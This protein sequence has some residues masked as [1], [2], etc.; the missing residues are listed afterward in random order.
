M[1]VIIGNRA[2]R[3]PGLDK[4]T[5]FVFTSGYILLVSLLLENM[6]DVH[7]TIN[8]NGIYCS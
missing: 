1:I 3:N 4:I 6:S 2:I 8:Q 7:E 5:S